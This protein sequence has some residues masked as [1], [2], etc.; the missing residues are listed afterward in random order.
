MAHLAGGRQVLEIKAGSLAAGVYTY[1]LTVNGK[2]A[3]SK[4]MVLTR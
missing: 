4:R 1:T 3:T 2:E